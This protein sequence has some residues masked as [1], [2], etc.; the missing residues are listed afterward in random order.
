MDSQQMLCIV[1][2][3]S[4]LKPFFREIYASNT[5]PDRVTRFPSAV[6]CNSDPLEERG[7]H[8]IGFWFKNGTECEFYDSFGRLPNDYDI[9]L[10][11][12]IDR[13]SFVCVYNNVQVQPN[14]SSTCG[15]HVLFYLYR[16]SRGLSMENTL[17]SLSHFKSDD[18]VREI[19]FE[20]KKNEKGN[21]I[22]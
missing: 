12:F 3:L 7:T 4:E 2:S 6:V 22:I 5:L 14:S 17:Q 9:R 8:W 10:R 1:E 20:R 13:N 11:E 16:R 21:R 15:Y 18:S 19:F